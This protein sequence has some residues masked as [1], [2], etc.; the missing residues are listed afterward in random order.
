MNEQT[1]SDLHP[2]VGV[3]KPVHI[4]F[5]SPFVYIFNYLGGKD[6]YIYRFRITIYYAVM[7]THKHSFAWFL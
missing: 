2:R 1:V 6:K 3:N 4:Y 5:H 7:A